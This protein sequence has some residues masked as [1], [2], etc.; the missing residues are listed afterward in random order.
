MRATFLLLIVCGCHQSAAL[1]RNSLLGVRAEGDGLVLEEYALG[2]EQVEM[3]ARLPAMTRPLLQMA[4]SGDTVLILDRDTLTGVVVD[5]PSGETRELRY[6]APP[7]CATFS[8]AGWVDEE[9][10]F[11]ECVSSTSWIG[12]IDGVMT[13]LSELVG[14][15][16]GL[17]G[18]DLI[19]ASR[20]HERLLVRCGPSDFLVDGQG[21]RVTEVLGLRDGVLLSAI[22]SAT[23]VLAPRTDAE[24]VRVVRFGA[25]EQSPGV[26]VP[27]ET[28]T[29]GGG[30][31]GPP[32]F[33][34]WHGETVYVRRESA[35]GELLRF[36]G[37]ES[38]DVPLCDDGAPPAVFFP[39]MR[40]SLLAACSAA[41][42]LRAFGADVVRFEV[43]E[44]D[45]LSMQASGN[46]LLVTSAA[47]A[48]EVYDME[49]GELVDAWPGPALAV[50]WRDSHTR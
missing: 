23:E 24:G 21:T 28:T 39:P 35:N 6:L 13:P 31:L 2:A 34:S 42:E 48:H 33:S 7:A 8:T 43:G 46:K 10:F 47:E 4:A 3:V 11:V 9:S 5:V 16:A 14:G 26:L 50:E 37:S 19:T 25:A 20:Q 27:Y 18:C 17:S 22:V 30:L 38:L 1:P 45:A 36:D 40:D 49:S 41:L 44:V 15:L 32:I 29:P 12:H